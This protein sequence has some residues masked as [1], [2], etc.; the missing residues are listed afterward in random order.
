M[1]HTPSYIIHF[2]A[3]SIPQASLC[4]PQNP[5][6][7]ESSI[8]HCVLCTSA[9]TQQ[10]FRFLARMEMRRN[11]DLLNKMGKVGPEITD[12]KLHLQR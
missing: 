12:M 7:Q 4:P 8:N 5:P 10:R 3:Q 1:S 2:N 9:K 6:V 11:Y